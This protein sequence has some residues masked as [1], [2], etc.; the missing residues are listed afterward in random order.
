MA[1]GRKMNGHWLSLIQQSLCSESLGADLYVM[2][3]SERL[4]EVDHH[5][6]ARFLKSEERIDHRTFYCRQNDPPLTKN[7]KEIA[8]SAAIAARR[9]Y[10]HIG[11]VFCSRLR[12]AIETG[13]TCTTST[14][15]EY[16]IRR[17][18]HTILFPP[19]TPS[20]FTIHFFQHTKL[21]SSSDARSTSRLVSLSLLL[22]SEM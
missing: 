6:F 17:N 14:Y 21:R 8:R 19:I 20:P 13:T 9:L 1:T 12:R 10:P 18:A 16:F 5:E 22:L 15:Y 3:H 11:K 4:D 2:R 7:G